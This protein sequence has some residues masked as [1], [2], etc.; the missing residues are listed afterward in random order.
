LA[1]HEYFHVWN[2]KR[3]RPAGLGPFN[4]EHETY[5]QSLW[6]VEGITSYYQHVLLRR[7]GFNRRADLLGMAGSLIASVQRTPGRLV[8]SLSAASFDTWIK[9][10]R[11]DENSVN[12]TLSYYT[13]GSLAALLLDAEIRRVSNDAKSLDDVMRAA[14][15]RYSGATG[16]TEAQFIALTSE[17]AGHDLSAWFQRVVQA[18]GQWDYQ[19]ML[20]WYGLAFE[21]SNKT[22]FVSPNG[23]ESPDPRKGWLGADTKSADGRLVVTSVRDDTPAATAGLC[24]DDEIIAIDQ[25]RVSA[26]D[27]PNRLAVYAPGEKIALLISRRDQLVTLPLTLGEEPRTTWRIKVRSDATDAQK[28]HLRTWIGEDTPAQPTPAGS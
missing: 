10:Y 22:D 4:Y 15:A 28:A 6:V 12:T 21:Q 13:G 14:Y 27:L 8:Q 23:I 19:P 25:Y 9:A 7:A 17:V 16:Y 26:Q 5:T 2:G 1:S 20:D 3:L 18:P 11:P 24:V